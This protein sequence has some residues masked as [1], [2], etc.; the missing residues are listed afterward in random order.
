LSGERRL[1]WDLGGHEVSAQVSGAPDSAVALLL[2]HGASGDMRGALMQELIAGLA[3]REVLVLAFNFPYAEA[4]KKS[5]PKAEAAVATF[6]QASELAR[7][8]AGGRPLAAGGRSYGGRVAT[9]AAAAGEPYAA[10]ACFAYPFHAPGRPEQERAEHFAAI[11]CPVLI[12]QGTRDPFVSRP[13][14]LEAAL[15]R[16]PAG[17][18]LQWVEGAGH[19]LRDPATRRL[20]PELL[21]RATAFL[22][23]VGAPKG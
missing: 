22:H 21:D 10:L 20:P 8:E 9:L 14:R 4:G 17:S 2:G 23:S 15:K 19:D 12:C 3:A 18:A 5:P 11:T 13:E 7:R 6:R 16:L 1:R